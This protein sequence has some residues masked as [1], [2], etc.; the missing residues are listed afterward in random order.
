MNAD[1]MDWL[2]PWNVD[3]CWKLVIVSMPLAILL[4]TSPEAGKQVLQLPVYSGH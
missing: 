1:L 4:A 3:G 2:V